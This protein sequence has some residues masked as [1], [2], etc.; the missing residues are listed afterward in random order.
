MSYHLVQKIVWS[1]VFVG[2]IAL[3]LL[4][5]TYRIGNAATATRVQVHANSSALAANVKGRPLGI[6]RY[7]G[8]GYSLLYDAAWQATP[9]G[10]NGVSISHTK[11][12]LDVLVQHTTTPISVLQ[13]EFGTLARVN[14]QR[15]GHVPRTTMVAGT[16]WDLARYTCASPVQ[17]QRSEEIV[18]LD[19]KE[20]IGGSYYSIAV[21]ATHGALDT[22]T[23]KFIA[24]FR[25]E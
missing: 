22:H 8:Q 11:T 14:C 9:D 7:T 12:R 3:P 25:F 4:L 1:T 5:A 24:S 20:A 6:V 17:G 19:T 23:F 21:V 18:T 15:A 13:F 16:E 2:F 10:N